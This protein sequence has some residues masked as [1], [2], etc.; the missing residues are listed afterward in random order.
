MYRLT[1]TILF[2]FLSL[3]NM[4]GRVMPGARPLLA[5]MVRPGLVNMRG[6][7][8]NLRGVP[9]RASVQRPGM[10]SVRAAPNGMPMRGGLQRPMMR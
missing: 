10:P 9:F 4:R 8:A 2:C 3:G 1:S 7:P 6:G 5:G